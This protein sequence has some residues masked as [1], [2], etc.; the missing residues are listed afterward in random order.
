MKPA[1]NYDFLL[2]TF[3]EMEDPELSGP[4]QKDKL[5][6]IITITVQCDLWCRGLVRDLWFVAISTRKKLI[7]RVNNGIPSHDTFFPSLCTA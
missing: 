4:T 2:T 7:F 6:D 3:G 5:I 1:Q